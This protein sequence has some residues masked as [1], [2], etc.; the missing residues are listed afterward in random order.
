MESFSENKD[1]RIIFLDDKKVKKSGSKNSF[2]KMENKKCKKTSEEFLEKE[3]SNTFFE[4]KGEPKKRKIIEGSNWC[5]EIEDYEYEN[6][7]NLLQSLQKKIEENLPLNHKEKLVF[8]ELNKKICGY[9]NQDCQ[10]QKFDNTKFITIEQVLKR[11]QESE[12]K[13]FYCKENLQLI[14]QSVREPK[15][16]SVE[17]IDN[18]FGHNYDNVE[19]ACL[20]CNLHRKTMYHERFL[21][22]KQMKNIVKI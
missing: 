13:C 17:R 12:L 4:K 9:K 3:S 11:L 20:T 18:S 10:K 15:Q 19:M 2:Q 22:T 6:Q 8:Q 16:W 21:F 14:Y 7:Q 5:F 1:T